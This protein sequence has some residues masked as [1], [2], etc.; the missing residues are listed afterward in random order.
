MSIPD[1][2]GQRT[3]F[4]V[5]QLCPRLFESL[6]ESAASET[7]SCRFAFFAREVWPKLV[8]L[9]PRLEAMYCRENG[10]PAEEPVRMLGAMILQFMERMPDREAAEACTYDLRWKLALHLEADAEGF[11]PTSLVRF[12]ERLVKHG[13]ER[14]GFEGVLS[15]LIEKGWLKRH[16]KQRLDS[17]HVLGL[18]ARMGQLERMRETIRLALEELKETE[19]KPQRWAGWCERYVETRT[20]YRSPEEALRRKLLQAGADAAAILAWAEV[21]PGAASREPVKLLR[22]VFDENF[23]RVE[24]TWQARRSQPP[25]AVHNPHDPEAHW[26]TKCAAQPKEKAWVGYKVQVAETVEDAP[27]EKGEPTKSFITSIVTQDATASD[28]AG[29]V[30]TLEEQKKLD[31]GAPTTLYADAGYV[32]GPALAQARE[33]GREL[34]GP[35]P[36]APQRGERYASEAFA[37]DVENRR[38]VCPQGHSSTNCSRLEVE[39]TG[40]VNYRFEWVSACHDCPVR[41]RCVGEGQRHRTLVVGEHHTLVQARRQEMRT[42]AFRDDMK[43]R[44]GIEGTQSEMVR[45]YGL[46]QARYRGRKKIQLQN[47]LIGA[48]CNVRRWFRRILWEA[49]RLATGPPAVIPATG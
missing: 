39:A 20:D 4:D 11:H 21:L 29:L 3:F 47:C 2:D 10:R 48:A 12:R 24:E 31:M 23:E 46:R 33:E 42:E 15:A 32:S 30:E 1:M 43:R 7:P 18:V 40:K 22:R 38:A 9:R 5:D 13:L 8:A 14:I 27:R 45:G 44:N 37:V 26:S 6:R 28:D 49:R 25:G 36:A 19:S 41:E 17:T 35:I 16:A 34:H